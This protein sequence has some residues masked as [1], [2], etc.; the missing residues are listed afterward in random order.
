M[1]KHQWNRQEC[2][3]SIS[4]S[5]SSVECDRRIQL[6]GR[7]AVQIVEGTSQIGSHQIHRRSPTHAFAD[8][9]DLGVSPFW[10]FLEVDRC[11]QHIHRL[12]RAIDSNLL[13]Y[14]E[15][16]SHKRMSLDGAEQL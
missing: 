13:I 4:F 11:R 6:R 7:L 12:I 3:G 14:K 8:V 5:A 1:H 9:P 10:T 2:L 16:Q 15:V